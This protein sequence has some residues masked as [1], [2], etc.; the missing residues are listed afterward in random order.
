L[1]G[2]PGKGDLDGS[3]GFYHNIT[4][5]FDAGIDIISSGIDS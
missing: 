2:S 5:N 1:K 4:K 3:G